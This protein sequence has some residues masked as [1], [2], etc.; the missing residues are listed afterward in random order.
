MAKLLTIHAPELL[1]PGKDDA[2]VLTSQR[3][4]VAG[5]ANIPGRE[6]FSQYSSFPI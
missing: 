3:N 2:E 5:Y 1:N 6:T 4:P